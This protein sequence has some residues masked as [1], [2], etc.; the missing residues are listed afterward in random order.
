[1]T[2]FEIIFDN[3]GGATLQVN[4][5]EYV[6]NYD[7]MH[8]LAIDVR[9]IVDGANVADW[10][11]NEPECYID[12]NTYLDHAPNGGYCAIN[13]DTWMDDH[14]DSSWGNVRQFS[15]AMTYQAA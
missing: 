6:H 1:M 11:G 7:D 2:I 4:G 14:A 12:E 8:Q 3:G 9:A 15:G 10:D 5:T 13:Q